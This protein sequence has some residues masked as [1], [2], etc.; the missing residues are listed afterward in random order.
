[1]ASGDIAFSSVVADNGL[2]RRNKLRDSP[3]TKGVG[4]V[5]RPT[6]V[7]AKFRVLVS[8]GQGSIS[9]GFGI[10]SRRRWLVVGVGLL[11]VRLTVG[12]GRLA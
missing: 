7:W 4:V 6:L 11:E 9:A 10:D 12:L 1:M 2:G 8:E 5:F 3:L